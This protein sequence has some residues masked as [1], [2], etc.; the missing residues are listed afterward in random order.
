[1]P[2]TPAC[3]PRVGSTVE[4]AVG[5][6]L[7]VPV[8]EGE[9]VAARIVSVAVPDCAPHLKVTSYSAPTRAS[10]STVVRALWSSPGMPR[11]TRSKTADSAVAS[12]RVQLVTVRSTAPPGRTA[13]GETL[14]PND[15]AF[16]RAA[17]SSPRASAAGAPVPSSVAPSPAAASAVR[18]VLIER[19]LCRTCASPCTATLSR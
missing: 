19:L 16:G 12:C 2:P 9:A 15:A 18:S 17:C 8:G 4:L 10:V 13:A 5:V 7:D 3:A 14:N 1:M 11:T 6:A